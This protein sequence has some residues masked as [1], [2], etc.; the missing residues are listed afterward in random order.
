MTPANGMNPPRYSN[1]VSGPMRTTLTLLLFLD[2]PEFRVA[3]NIE[4]WTLAHGRIET[5]AVA[6]D[7]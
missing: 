7:R 4:E 2:N 3:R 5:G 1:K 6:R